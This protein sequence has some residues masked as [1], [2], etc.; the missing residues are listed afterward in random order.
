[1]LCTGVPE[2]DIV[3]RSL[4]VSHGTA[5]AFDVCVVALHV[6]QAALQ[7]FEHGG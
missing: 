5:D 7:L 2:H 1:M 6:L 4:C 3:K